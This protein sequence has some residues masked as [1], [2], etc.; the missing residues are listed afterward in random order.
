M[1]GALSPDTASPESDPK[2]LGQLI[3]SQEFGELPGLGESVTESQSSAAPS[4]ESHFQLGTD[5]KFLPSG[6]VSDDWELPVCGQPPKQPKEVRGST[7]IP[8]LRP[9]ETHNHRKLGLSGAP[10]ALDFA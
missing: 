7:G 8:T 2:L 10:P 9:S 5:C 6:G 1:V 3:T 4:H